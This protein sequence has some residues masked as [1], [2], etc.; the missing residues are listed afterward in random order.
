[1]FVRMFVDV[2][3]VRIIFETM[4]LCELDAALTRCL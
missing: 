4:T 1:M 2:F 3:V